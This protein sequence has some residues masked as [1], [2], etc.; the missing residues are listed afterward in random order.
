MW[1]GAASVSIITISTVTLLSGAAS[2]PASASVFSQTGRLP[3][4]GSTVASG[5]TSSGLRKWKLTSPIPGPST[6]GSQGIAVSGSTAIVG[7]YNANSGHGVAYVFVQGNGKWN[8]QAELTPSDTATEF[9]DSVALSGSTVI[10]GAPGSQAAYIFVGSGSAWTQQAKLTT[11]DASELFGISVAV[12]GSTA[13][14]GTWP[15]SNPEAAYVFQQSGGTWAQTARF[16]ASDPQ[17]AQWFGLSVAV[18]GSTVVVGA[19]GSSTSS[20]AAYVFKQSGSTWSQKQELTPTAAVAGQ[21]FGLSVAISGAT[22]LVG[23]AGG[24]TS[25]AAYVF[26]DNNGTWTE[27]T[28]LTASD[29]SATDD[30]GGSVALSGPTAVV[31]AFAKAGGG[32]AY[33]FLDSS[34]SWV[35]NTELLPPTTCKGEFG[36]RVAVSRHTALVNAQGFHRVGLVFVYQGNPL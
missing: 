15:G 23:S 10:I 35:Q 5:A 32:A 9:G 26:A 7:D 14:V 30:F 11:T 36:D 1:R 4:S 24:T 8:L 21:G 19:Q 2:P 13:V 6:F 20:G 34:G 29:E 16:T 25:G 33:V 22:L 18:S 31:G 28:K 3:Q 17:Q 12:S 27:Q